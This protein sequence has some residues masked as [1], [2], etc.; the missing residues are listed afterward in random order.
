MDWVAV[1]AHVDTEVSE[2]SP[3]PKAF[4]PHSVPPTRAD[5]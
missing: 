5:G 2:Q 4:K 1:I 3:S